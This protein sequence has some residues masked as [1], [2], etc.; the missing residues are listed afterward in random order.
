MTKKETRVELAGRLGC[1]KLDLASAYEYAEE[2][3]EAIHELDAENKALTKDL[4]RSERVRV[5]GARLLAG[6]RIKKRKLWEQLQE[7]RG[8][9]LWHER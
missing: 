8:R 2:L 7:C 3:T 1:L 4:A 6:V 9:R 5:E